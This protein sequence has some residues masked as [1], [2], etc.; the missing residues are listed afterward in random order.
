MGT[1]TGGVLNMVAGRSDRSGQIDKANNQIERNVE[2]VK[3]KASSLKETL[4]AEINSTAEQKL[5]AENEGKGVSQTA[6]EGPLYFAIKA[7]YTGD[8]SSLNGS[9]KDVANTFRVVLSGSPGFTVEAEQIIDKATKKLE[10][11]N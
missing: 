5:K 3:Q 11:F 4:M 6:G 7:L 1:K 2:A 8:Y 10:P 9:E